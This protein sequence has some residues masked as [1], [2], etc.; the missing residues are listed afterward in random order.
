VQAQDPLSVTLADL[1]HA[2]LAARRLLSPLAPAEAAQLVAKLL[3][4]IDGPG[5]DLRAEVVRRTGGV[6]FFVV[7]CAQELR[8][9]GSEGGGTLRRTGEGVG[10]WAVAQSVR[11]RVAALPEGVKAIL[12][13]AAVVGRVVPHTLLGNVTGRPDADLF[14]ALE[15]ACH[16]G[17]LAEDGEAYQFTHDVIREVIE[18]DVGLAQRTVLHRRVAEALEQRPG[19][20]PVALLAYHYSRTEEQ[21]KALLYMEQAGDRAAAHRAHAA[22]Q[23]YYQ[24]ALD[25]LD[26]LGRIEGAA[27]VCEKL[28][29]VLKTMGRYDQALR[30]LERAAAI[31]R[32]AADLEAEGRVT[33][34]IGQVHFNAGTWEEG[35]ARV[36]SL[37]AP[38]QAQ[39]PSPALATLYVALIPLFAPT[40]RYREYLATAERA[41]VLAR[42]LGDG[43]LL[44]ESEVWRGIALAELDRQVE[45]RPVLEGAVPLAEAAHHLRSHGRALAFL[46]RIYLADGAFAHACGVQEQ[47]IEVSEQLGDL[48]FIGWATTRLAD[49]HVLA[50]T[51]TQARVLYER[52]VALFR[53]LGGA[54]RYF[55]L[56]FVGLGRL[57]L[58]EGNWEEASRYLEEGAALAA[59]TRHLGALRAA[60]QALAERD[61]LDGRPLAAFAR[62][63]TLLKDLDLE[64]SV[65]MK[66]MPA[67]AR[68]HLALGNLADAEALVVAGVSR[69]HERC[70]R[71]DLVEWLRLQGMVGI[72]Q[73][74][75]QDAQGALE[76]AI[77]LTRG[78]P[79][80]YAEGCLLQVYGE[81]H[82]RT[83]KARRAR[84]S[85]EA[86]LA[87]FRRLG[88]HRDAD[89]VEQAVAGLHE[90]PRAV[91][92]G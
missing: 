91:S 25:R 89:Q 82:S 22:A 2:G 55:S 76:E 88:A 15:A 39:G 67:L 29:V 41:S 43:W 74:R 49:V 23:G 87:I 66:P 90:A 11:Q 31:H 12:G 46:G 14:A 44:A 18:H 69:A 73:G 30:M 28:G 54:T 10:P 53:S 85:L 45:A 75:Y 78:M 13:A 47:A 26:Q 84:E 70:N 59:H 19:E 17:L 27:R 56:P 63:R 77:V 8:A 40:G 7:S 38:L 33:A 48:N 35:I 6:P 86:A 32:M 36:R 3:D 52:A 79:Y 20:P 9:D 92:P 4:G 62:L 58:H 72:R 42:S 50:G 60:Q 61:L 81:L 83:G 16:A 57:S 1:A 68:V 80:P 21:A 71:V 51:W 65:L 37:L 5:M 24:Q 34:V 64:D